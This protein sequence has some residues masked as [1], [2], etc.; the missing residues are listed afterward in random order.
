VLAVG[1]A[2]FQK[3]CLG[4]MGDVSKGEG[5]TVL[6][7][8]HNMAAVQNL[9]NKGILL[10]KGKVISQGDVHKVLGDYLNTNQYEIFPNFNKDIFLSNFNSY[11]IGDKAKPVV[12]GLNAIFE[13]EI[14]SKIEKDDILIGLGINDLYG[15]RL[16]TPFSKHTNNSFH[17]KK[18]LNRI[19]CEIEKFPLKPSTYNLEVYVGT[20]KE[21]YDYYDKG[22]SMDV[23]IIGNKDLLY[24]P[25]N[26][27]GSFII[28][29]KWV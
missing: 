6:F 20:E 28:N 14:T 15:N 29:Q 27:Q 8:S 7:V 9:C 3:K 2:E 21:I 24:I 19:V 25:D 26:T 13:F 11:T 4:K 1:D 17:I 10:D 18:G 5:R 22:L 16:I 23:E 12:A